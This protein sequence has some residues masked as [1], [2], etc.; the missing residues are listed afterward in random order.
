MSDGGGVRSGNGSPSTSW[1]CQVVYGFPGF[2]GAGTRI[3]ESR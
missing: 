1:V 2:D 3:S